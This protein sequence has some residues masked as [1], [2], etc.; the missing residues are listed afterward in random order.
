MKKIH[1]L[2]VIC[3]L[4][5]ISCIQEE[6][7]PI[8][9][10]DPF[11]GTGFHGHTYPGATA[12]YGAVQLSPDTRKGN[13]DACSGYHYSDSTIIGFSHTHLSGT[14]CIDL[15]DILFHPTTRDLNPTN[16][17][18][19]FEPLSFSHKD[20]KAS[21]GYY[22]VYFPEEG[23]RAELTATTYTGVH[24]Y[25]YDKGKKQHLI[26]DLAHLL[27]NEVIDMVAVHQTASNEI[28]GMRR[29]QGWTPNQ[30][31][32]FVAQFS[33]DF[34]DVTFMSDGEIQLPATDSDSQNR[35]VLLSFGTSDGTPI[36]AKV[37]I[38][39]V[40]EDNA[41]QNMQEDTRDFNFD[42][43]HAETRSAWENALSDITVEGGSEA[44]LKIFYTAQYHTKIIPNIVS[45]RNGQYRRHD[46]AIAQASPGSEQYST[47]SIWDT[48][49]AWN[50]LMTLVNPELVNAMIRSFL[51]VYKT[52]GELPIW[53]LS[54]GETGT[55]IGYHSV[56]VIADAYRKGIR[57]YDVELAFEAMKRSSDINS[58]G[59]DYYVKYGF[60]PSNIKRESVSCLL[61]YAYDDWCIAQMAKELGKDTDY[62][63][64]KQRALS[65]IHVFDGYTRF[66]RGKRMDG[67]WDNS[68]NP[69]EPGRAYTEA[70]AWQYRFFV[71]HDVNG[72]IQLFGGKEEF[73]AQLDSLFLV[74]SAVEGEMVDITGLIGQYAH[75]NEPSHH[76]AYLYNYV[77]QPWKTQEMTRRIL[78][79]MYLPT[80]EGI[81]GNEDCGQMS[82]WY[83]FSSLGFYPVC[84]GT[85]E[86]VF[87]APLFKKA[88]I[89]LANGKRLT[90][91]ANSSAKNIYIEQVKLNGREIEKNFLTY[92]QLMEGGLLE[93]HLVEQPNR[94]RGVSE[95]A[96]PYSLTMEPVV[97]IP[98]TTKDLYLFVGET[99]VDLGTATPG[100]TI[101]Y[102]LDGTEPNRNSTLY[103]E[104]FHL[105]GTRTIR[106]K[107]FKEGYQPSRTFSIEA[108]KAVFDNPR[109]MK[110]KENGTDY[111]YYEGYFQWVA[112][113]EKTPVKAQGIMPSPSIESA[114]QEDH[115]AFIFT[116]YL[117][118]P[119]DGIYEFMT[120]SDDGSVLYINDKKIVDNDGSHAAIM[121]NGRIALKKGYHTYKLMYFEDYEGEHLSWGWKTPSSSAFEAIPESNLYIK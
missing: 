4:G 117:W 66:F 35:Q 59:S 8:D 113:I 111:R 25:T 67:N 91:E 109:I 76:M 15:G 61:E 89:R 18:S 53:P 112:D 2:S 55:M 94:G 29:T 120:R 104:P 60:I 47:F 13:W 10:V 93:Y 28:S 21:P 50:P 90:I 32:Y 108:T 96:S 107:A 31:I 69:F 24:R 11:I 38:S 7:K 83:V 68:F 114:R 121:A 14:G 16:N 40:S 51:E 49:R 34:Q 99:M 118:A 19:V 54:A 62:E 97:S 115:F 44:D 45:D 9:Y 119:E 105:S 39:I 58:K 23:I 26:I 33:S 71:P 1:L 64:Y 46:M 41:R 73:T 116:G 12:P 102:T 20:E 57:D 70:T 88:T 65:Y 98:Y 92:E 103:K 75:G 6:K 43:I 81:I 86:F 36:V 5:V 82:A 37:G 84:P 56:S 85:G 77:G 74:E 101:C 100:A 78:K 106:A 42:V 52:T 22:S 30:Y 63:T 110:G 80:P 27:E 3:L 79:E 17:G 48:F 87:T 95:E 72:M